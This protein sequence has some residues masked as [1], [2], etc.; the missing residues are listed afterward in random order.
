M[1]ESDQAKKIDFANA[2]QAPKFF[3]HKVFLHLWRLSPLSQVQTPNQD[4]SSSNDDSGSLYTK[5]CCT[6]Y[7]SYN[8]GSCR[9]CACLKLDRRSSGGRGQGPDA[10]PRS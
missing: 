9:F 10:T 2:S 8:P 1:D 6:P 7:L 3:A 4:Q 5:A